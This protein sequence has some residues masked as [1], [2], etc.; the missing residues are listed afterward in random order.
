MA[1]YKEFSRQ[2]KEKYPEYKNVDDLKLAKAMIKK[3]PQYEKQVTFE[4]IAKEPTRPRSRKGFFDYNNE[5]LKAD[6]QNLIDKRQEWEQNH[7]YISSLQKDFQPGYRSNLTEWQLRAKYGTPLNTPLSEEIN[8]GFKKMGQDV[9][10]AVNLGVSAGTGGMLN[11]AKGLGQLAARGAAQGA[12]QG[13]VLSAT[14]ELGN[15][16]LSLNVIPETLK[17]TALGATVGA[18]FPPVLEGGGRLINASGNLIKRGV[19]KLAQISPETV[20]QVIKPTSK[21]LDYTKE[22]AQDVLRSTTERV[23][24]AYNNLLGQKGDAIQAAEENLRN[25]PDRVNVNDVL[26]DITNTFNK[27]QGENINPARNMTGNLETNLSNLVESGTNSMD[28]VYN[29]INQSEKPKFYSKEKEAEAYD[30]LS[31]ATG[32]SVN[33]LKSQLNSNNF[34][35]GIGKR[36]EFID[37]LVNNLDDRLEILKSGDRNSYKYYYDANLGYGNRDM[38]DVNAAER[39]VRQAYDD[40]INRN[41]TNETLDPLSQELAGAEQNY[42]Y[43]LRNVLENSRDENIMSKAFDKLEKSIK[44]LPEEIQEEYTNKFINDVEKILQGRNTISPIDLQKIKQQVGQMTNWADTTRPK[45]QNTVLEQVYGKM[46]NRLEDLSPELAQ[47]NKEYAAL[48]GFQ[49]DEGLKTI[50]APGGAIDRAS[51]TLKNYNSTVSKGNTARNIQALEDVLTKQGEAPFLDTMDDINAAMDLLKHERT[52]LGSIAEVGKSII[53]RPALR[54]AR[55]YNQSKLPQA[56][57]N[58]RNVFQ[59]AAIPFIYNAPRLYGDV[60]YDE[61]LEK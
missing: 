1:D 36:K 44:G 27:Y 46:R 41:F 51:T 13:G 53:T 50:L 22:K 37:S 34:K 32:K 47:A 5:D 16:G 55:W 56:F 21:A 48:K 58:I 15:N 11:G 52:G 14:S 39:L 30:I 12:I 4:N 42:K 8:A 49:D 57:G 10:P 20:E 26:G 9:I 17:G 28:D 7:P 24:N 54:A 61:Y 60:D 19:G 59:R 43:I 31:K 6:Y 40:I 38:T 25:V 33:W 23:R 18:A 29:Y 3:Y 2:I 35:D 45:I